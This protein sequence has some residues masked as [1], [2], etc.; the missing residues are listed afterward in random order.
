MILNIEIVIKKYNKIKKKWKSG[1]IFI[2][3]NNNNIK[4]KM[5]ITI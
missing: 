5:E 3:I 4:N 1:T 2:Y